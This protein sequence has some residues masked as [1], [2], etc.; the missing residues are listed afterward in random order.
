VRD[1]GSQVTC[2]HFYLVGTR[3]NLWS[4]F[5]YDWGPQATTT[6]LHRRVSSLG[7]S[8]SKQ[9]ESKSGRGNGNSRPK[10][11]RRCM[12]NFGDIVRRPKTKVAKQPVVGLV[13]ASDCLVYYAAEDGCL[14]ARFAMVRSGSQ[15][16]ARP[17]LSN[18]RSQDRMDYASYSKKSCTNHP[19]PACRLECTS[20]T[21]TTV[22]LP[23]CMTQPLRLAVCISRTE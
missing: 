9:E 16:F 5:S 23:A 6:S 8:A 2:H 3:Q 1:L 11:R 21:G 10:V 7:S 17:E 14:C 19:K 20:S 18:P 22:L 13:L 12:A 4:T 15:W